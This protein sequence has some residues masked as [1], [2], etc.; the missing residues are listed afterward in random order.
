LLTRKILFK[1]CK[2]LKISLW[3]LNQEFFWNFKNLNIFI[4]LIKALNLRLIK[5]FLKKTDMY[6]KY[7]IKKMFYIWGAR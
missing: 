3:R 4:R 2:Y 7:K 1:L 6:V 5:I